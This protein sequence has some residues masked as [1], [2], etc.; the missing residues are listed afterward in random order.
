MLHLKLFCLHDGKEEKEDKYKKKKK[1]TKSK[2]R[3]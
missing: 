1:P 3:Q 2:Q